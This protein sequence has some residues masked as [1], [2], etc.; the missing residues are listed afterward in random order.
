MDPK[1]GLILEGGALRGLFTTGVIDVLMEQGIQLDGLVGVSAGATFGCNYV[2]YQIRR[3]LRYCIRFAKDPRFCSV[4]SLLKT[5]DMY[6]AEFCYH[7]IPEELD[8]IDND[9]FVQ[10]GMPFYAVATDVNTGQAVYHRCDSLCGDDLEWVRASASMPLVSQIVHVGGYALL[11]GGIADS[12]PL[13]FF[14]H[15]GY[16]RNV[17]V[18]TQ[19]LGY[20]KQSNPMMPLVRIRYRKYPR[21]IDAMENRHLIYNRQLRMVAQAEADGTAF[22]IRPPEKLPIDHISHDEDD[23]RQVYACGRNTMLTLL[24]LLRR[25]LGI[26]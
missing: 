24:P 16:S 4:R 9:T 2:T 6:G 5:G 7:T 21:L 14:V 26:E 25:L 11:D 18:L 19:P 17:I 1:T 22:V 23:M 15:K 10:S 12:I 8:V 3:P 20:Q 13:R